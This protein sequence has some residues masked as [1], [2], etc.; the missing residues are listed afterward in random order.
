MTTARLLHAKK[1]LYVA[2]ETIARTYEEYMPEDNTFWREGEPL[3]TI[4]DAQ[5][6]NIA[7]EIAGD[8]RKM[9]AKIYTTMHEELRA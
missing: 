6:R 4:T 7:R 1:P 9:Y 2:V 5:L 3:Y 8:D